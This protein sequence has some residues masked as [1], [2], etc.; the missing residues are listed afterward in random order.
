M[1]LYITISYHT[2]ISKIWRS[3]NFEIIFLT[4]HS[5]ISWQRYESHFLNGFKSSFETI[6]NSLHH[7][8]QQ[9]WNF[10]NQE[11]YIENSV[12]FGNS[13]NFIILL[14][15]LFIHLVCIQHALMC[16]VFFNP[17]YDWKR[18]KGHHV[19]N[20]KKIIITQTFNESLLAVSISLHKILTF[21]TML[22]LNG[23]LKFNSIYCS[24]PIA[25]W[26]SLYSSSWII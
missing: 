12:I 26:L 4:V 18:I 11:L 7:Y 20:A 2:N 19:M 5:T 15:L 17:P 9:Q 25:D 1:Q 22:V 16:A 21:C 14:F 13:V 10:I 3:I 8:L 6:N 23:V 24:S